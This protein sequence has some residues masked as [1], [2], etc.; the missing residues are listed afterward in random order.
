MEGSDILKRLKKIIILIFVGFGFLIN[1]VH[2]EISDEDLERLKF[3]FTD[4][5][6]SIMSEEEKRDKLTNLNL[7][8]SRQFTKNFKGIYNGNNGSYTWHEISDQ[9]CRNHIQNRSASETLEDSYQTVIKKVKLVVTPYGDNH[10]YDA[11][12]TAFWYELPVMR[13]FDVMALRFQNTTYVPDSQFGHQFYRHDGDTYFSSVDYSS[14]GTNIQKQLQGFGISM[15]LV[16]D[17]DIVEFELLIGCDAII[18]NAEMP[19]IFGTYQHAE[20]KV[21][22]AQSQMY[23]IH[24]A[25]NGSVLNFVPEIEPRYDNMSGVFVYLG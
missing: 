7:E 22:L 11:C 23:N 14:N 10:T 25:G 21:S 17:D 8:E 5:H 3:A 13:S 20:R 18:T 12:L 15:N 4:N 16:N 9:E 2:A 19:Y 6:I 24:P 1:M